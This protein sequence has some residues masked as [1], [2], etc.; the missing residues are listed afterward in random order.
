M[1]FI[2]THA[3]IYLTEFVEDHRQMVERCLEVG[4]TKIYLP[5]I[6]GSTIEDMLLLESQYPNVCIPMMG[7]HPGSVKEDFEEQLKLVEYWL[8]KRSFAA[9][10]EI[11]SDFYWDTQFRDQ[12]ME[13]LSIQID[14]AHE[15]NLP[16]VVH[17]RSS[18]DDTC[19]LIRQKKK[20]G[21][22]GVFHCFGGS[23]EDAA[24]IAEMGFYLGIGGV[25]TFK[26]GSLEGVIPEI[27][28]SSLLLETDSPYLAPVPYRG[29]R[30]EPSY[31]P[32]IA[33]R[34]A[35]LKHVSIETIAQITTENA[36]NLF[37]DPNEV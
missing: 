27:P 36:L 16:I 37:A 26:N 31:L 35:D 9:V 6:D 30:N 22:R 1:K 21:L 17:T 20:K 13:A 14:W 19:D 23:V 18:F 10:G 29:K 28:N 32:V 34:L 4:V 24:L 5:N 15:L 11:G 12:Q 25:S 7:L 2:D 8:H 3:H 33:Q